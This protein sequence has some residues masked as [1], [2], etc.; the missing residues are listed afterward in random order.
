M[1]KQAR[2]GN[3]TVSDRIDRIVTN[4]ILALPIFVV[5][6]GVIYSIAMG[7]LPISIGQHQ[8]DRLGQ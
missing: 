1:H 8:R 4:R 7:Q 2:S 5:V 3:L 6:M